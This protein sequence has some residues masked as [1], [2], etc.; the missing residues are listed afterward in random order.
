MLK[1]AYEYGQRLAAAEKGYQD[2][3][4][5]YEHIFCDFAIGFL[6][7]D[8]IVAFSADISEGDLGV[9]GFFLPLFDDLQ[10][11]RLIHRRNVDADG[12][13]FKDRL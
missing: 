10:P 7:L 13:P 12:M 11:H 4:A 3:E 5:S 9:F 2:I 6:F 8:R 1:E